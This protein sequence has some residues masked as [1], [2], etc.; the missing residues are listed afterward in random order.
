MKRV[1]RRLV[2]IVLLLYAAASIVFLMLHLIP[3]DPAA[4]MLGDGASREDIEALRHQLGLDRP[5]S[6]QYVAWTGRLLKG[7]LGSSF[8]TATP[9]TDEILRA[10]P[11]TLELALIAFAFSLLIA[12]PTGVLAALRS[13]RLD[14][15]ALRWIALSGVSTPSYV[16][17]PLLALVFAVSLEWFPVSGREG[18][19]SAV[20]PA[21]T[22]VIS[23]SSLLSRMVRATVGEE[24]GRPYVL[25]ARARGENR[26]MAA[27]RHAGRNALTPF[28]T[29]AG[30][31]FGSLLTG[32]VLTETIFSWPGVGRLLIQSIQR[33]DYPMVQGCVLLIAAVY[34]L[35]N[36]AADVL[37]AFFD[38]RPASREGTH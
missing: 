28:L 37:S 6:T 30:L 5:L 26:W 36:S 22:L 16:S 23:V 10:F 13:G 17:G 14:D 1:A 18:P 24:L 32:A 31:Q 11:A 3:G 9:V 21:L 25:A 8:A 19:G 4:V 12:I 2:G 20:L 29:V 27:L 33:R 7:D 35:V 34:I 38:P 15:H